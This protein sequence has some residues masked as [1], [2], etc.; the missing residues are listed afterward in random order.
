MLIH[1]DPYPIHLHHWFISGLM[2]VAFGKLEQIL[3]ALIFYPL[4]FV[5]F[6]LLIYL[7]HNVWGLS[8][9][10]DADHVSFSRKQRSHTTLGTERSPPH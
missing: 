2:D 3:F 8:A 1:I 4:F 10:E 6:H 7:S 5:L 9:K